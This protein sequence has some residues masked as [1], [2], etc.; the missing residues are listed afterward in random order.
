VLAEDPDVAEDVHRVLKRRQ[1]LLAK[2]R[3]RVG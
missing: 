3:P 2:R 1:N